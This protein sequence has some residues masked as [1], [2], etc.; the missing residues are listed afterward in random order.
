VRAD[1]RRQPGRGDAGDTLIEILIALVVLALAAV[2]ILTAFTTAIWG[3]SDYRTIATVDTVVK[4]AAE[5]AI[6]QLQEQS[7]TQWAQCPGASQVT[8]NKPA[9]PTGYTATIAPQY[10]NG[11]SFQTNCIAD[12][13]ELDTISVTHNS[14]IYLISVIVDDPV[15]PPVL[16][17]QT[18]TSLA[19]VEQPSSP[20][21]VATIA[22]GADLV[23]W[24]QVA[25]EDS[26][27]DVVQDDLSSVTLAF[28]PRN[29]KCT[30]I[31]NQG[32][33][34]FG[35]CSVTK[36][37]SYT[38]TATDG[39]LSTTSLA[40]TIV[41]SLPTQL[42]YATPPPA[43]THTGTTFS[44]VV[45]EEDNYGNTVT[46]DSTSTVSLAANNGGG[47]FSCT[48]TSVKV[49]QGVA[50]FS[51]CSYGVTSATGYTLSATSGALTPATA[52]TVVS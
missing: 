30:G 20:S 29:A 24:P 47:G 18:V 14:N 45:D 40:F 28:S 23:P 27:G 8:F 44:V 16:V 9:L 13:A 48:S 12:S 2:S 35:D 22:A 41:P 10:W 34:S 4:T 21:N 49:T 3:A 39:S 46:T 25:V 7:T 5:E 33:F 6:T 51:N 17:G 11:S 52:V 37:G 32:T 43:T 15:I 42:V 31:E 26:S 38:L 1:G 36:T 50:T 19:F